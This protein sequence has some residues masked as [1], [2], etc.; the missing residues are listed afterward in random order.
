MPGGPLSRNRSNSLSAK[1]QAQAEGIPARQI[2]VRLMARC[3]IG[4][5]TTASQQNSRLAIGHP[6][7]APR[8]HPGALAATDI[9]HRKTMTPPIIGGPFLAGVRDSCMPVDTF[10]E[11]VLPCKALLLQV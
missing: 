7:P 4:H 6:L 8:R 11:G 9:D 10:C 2:A 1:G 3:I 5:A